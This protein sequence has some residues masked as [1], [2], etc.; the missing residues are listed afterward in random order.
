MKVTPTRL[1]GVRLVEPRT[2]ADARGFFME[3]YHEARYREA[4]ISPRF[5]Q[6]N[7]SCS[8][9]GVLRG[10]HYQRVQPQAKLVHVVHG[11]IFDV[12]VDI[13]KGSSHFGQ[14][15]GYV[16]SAKNK[17]QLYIPEGFAHGFFALSNDA[18]LHYKCSDFYAADDEKGIRWDDPDIGI[19]WPPGERILSEKDAAYPYLRQ[20]DAE[21]PLFRDHA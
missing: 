10:L 14:W 12:A 11:E 21:L 3:T 20:M 7:L 2:F 6:D 13:R 19:E 18:E 8:R 9:K 1:P 17:L 15:L 5:V 4:G 16:L